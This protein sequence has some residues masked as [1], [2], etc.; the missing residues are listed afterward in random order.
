MKSTLYLAA[1]ISVGKSVG[2][3]LSAVD[4]WHLFV[5]IWGGVSRILPRVCEDG[6]PSFFHTRT[7]S[8]HSFFGS[9][10]LRGPTL[11]PE[12]SQFVH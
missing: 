6:C 3:N 4:S 5:G 10:F 1:H 9:P 8:A 2:K 12:K 11:P 7:E